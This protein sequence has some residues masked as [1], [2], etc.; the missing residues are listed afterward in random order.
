MVDEIR[1]KIGYQKLA[2]AF[3]DAARL[4]GNIGTDKEPLL[5][6]NIT[7]QMPEIGYMTAEITLSKGLS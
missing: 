1:F 5:I 2:E 6:T 3:M 4:G 7:L